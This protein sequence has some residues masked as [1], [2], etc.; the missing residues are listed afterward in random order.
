M[1]LYVVFLFSLDGAGTD[2]LGSALVRR[3]VASLDAHEARLRAEDRRQS[4]RLE[5][6]QL[7]L[8]IDR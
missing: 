1:S 7:A 5:W 3:L 2:R 8:V 6:Q 4:I